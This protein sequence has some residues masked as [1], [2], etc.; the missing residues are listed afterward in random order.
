MANATSAQFIKKYP[1]QSD[2]ESDQIT[3]YLTEA[4][5]FIAGK[6]GSRLSSVEADTNGLEALKQAEMM[7]AFEA[8]SPKPTVGAGGERQ[9]NAGKAEGDRAR[10]ILDVW[11]SW[12]K[13]QTGV[14]HTEE[15]VESATFT[16]RDAETWGID[17]TGDTGST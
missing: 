14:V 8:L 13:G 15:L 2:R 9:L 17:D 1:A 7:L 16:P 12:A 10:G 6:F 3:E 4:Y 11:Y 5:A